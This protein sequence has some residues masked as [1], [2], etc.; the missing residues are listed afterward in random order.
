MVFSVVPSSLK[1]RLGL[2]QRIPKQTRH[3]YAACLSRGENVHKVAVH[4]GHADATMVLQTYGKW[5]K[6]Y[7]D[8]FLKQANA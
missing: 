2:R 4:M 5:I 7:E 8:E 6:Q 1:P 3:T